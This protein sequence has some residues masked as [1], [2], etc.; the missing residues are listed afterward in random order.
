MAPLEIT[1]RAF[2]KVNLD[3]RLVGLLPDGYHDVRTVLQTIRLHDTLCI[4]RTRG[5]LVIEC[6]TPG[7]PVDARNLVWKAAALLHAV[8]RG[9]TGEPRGLH[10]QLRKRIPA[11]AGLGGGSSD[12][13]A[14]LI[15]ASRL[16]R[17]RLDLPTLARL[18]ARLGA[19]VPFFL[20][21]GTAMGVGRGDDV[22]P[23]VEPPPSWVV[24]IC[25]EFGVSTAEAYRWYDEDARSRVR[26]P[27]RR[28]PADWPAW[29]A[30]VG[31]D[32]EAPVARR[33]PRIR[34]A[35]RALT[36]Q[37]AAYAAMSGSGSAVFG[38]FGDR[39]SAAAAERR[40]T[41]AGW[42]AMLSRTVSRAAVRRE[43]RR[44]LAGD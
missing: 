18:G 12:A 26:R 1:T 10:V 3:L 14:M 2:A 5:P 32:L 30:G 29:A 21:G 34:H 43:Q 8:V 42:R 23:L 15:A 16:W 17:L 35:V 20:S 24:L 44:A 6:D 28:L 38:V 13:A 4:R 11:E 27:A 40:L 33:H 31:N 37:G 19:D 7:V 22:S 36:R 41:A 25:P 9:G 39:E